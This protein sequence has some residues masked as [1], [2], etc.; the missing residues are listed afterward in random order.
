MN[1]ETV[2]LEKLGYILE[3]VKYIRFEEGGRSFDDTYTKRTVSI[4]YRPNQAKEIEAIKNRTIQG[5]SY[6]QNP[7]SNYQVLD[8]YNKEYDNALFNLV[9]KS[10]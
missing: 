7:L 10:I 9:L 6:Q 5:G 4:A 3:T 1:K 2:F 8:V